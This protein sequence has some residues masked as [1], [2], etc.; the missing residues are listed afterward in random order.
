MTRTL[1]VVATPI[2]NLKDITLRAL[3]TLKAVDVIA[4]ED[5]RQTAK[6]LSHYEIRKPMLRYDE[7]VHARA[8]A[9]ILEKLTL[10]H[11]VA[12]VTDAGT[13]GISDPGADLVQAVIK[14]GFYVVP[15]PGPSAASTAVSASGLGRGG[16]VFLG[17]LPRRK[18]RAE[19]SLRE[20][21]R[22]GKTLVIFES[23]FRLVDLLDL[24]QSVD[25][26][27]E[28]VV[29][30]ELTKIHEEF[31]R[32]TVAEV[33]TQLSTRPM[34]GEAVVLIRSDSESPDDFEEQ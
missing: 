12:L 30:R 20:A 4:C 27:A 26:G 13:P 28:V 8:V 17:F 29:A 6:L 14:G 2:G 33:R 11:D 21:L 31:I 16:Y 25:P 7:N 1:F 18:S 23:P 9:Q 32:G 22:L 5:T 19:R 3:E 24:T 10:G 15:I 34:K